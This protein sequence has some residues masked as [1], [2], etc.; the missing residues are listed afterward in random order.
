M[1]IILLQNSWK[2]AVK[3]KENQIKRLIKNNSEM[4]KT[5]DP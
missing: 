1:I 4:Y 3:K 2:Q 5:T